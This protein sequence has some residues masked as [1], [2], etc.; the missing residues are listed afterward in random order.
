VLPI[1]VFHLQPAYND[2]NPHFY[3][4][5]FKILRNQKQSL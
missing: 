5:L 4:H 3:R 2:K 1:T